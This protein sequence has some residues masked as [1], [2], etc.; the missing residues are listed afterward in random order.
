MASAA[1]LR[2]CIIAH[3]T[4]TNT[5]RQKYEAGFKVLYLF[6]LF[7]DARLALDAVMLYNLQARGKYVESSVLEVEQTTA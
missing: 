3:V 5:S 4:I 2:T 1:G 6:F 7:G